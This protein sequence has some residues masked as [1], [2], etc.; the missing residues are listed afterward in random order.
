M[1]RGRQRGVRRR[2][3][4]HRPRQLRPRPVQLQPANSCPDRREL[5]QHAQ[6]PRSGQG[7]R[8]R[9]PEQTSAMPSPTPAWS[10]WTKPTRWEPMP[11]VSPARKETAG[12]PPSSATASTGYSIHYDKVPLETR[13]QLGAVLPQD[14][15]RTKPDGC[16]RCIPRL[17]PAAGRRRLGQR[18]DSEGPS[19]LRADRPQIR[20]GSCQSTLLK[21]TGK[22]DRWDCRC[23]GL[24]VESRG[25]SGSSR[26]C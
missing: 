19:P 13:G 25:R 6:V 20:A 8:A 11:S 17:R 10:T 9:F 1:H 21:L 24:P 4:R 3:A 2:R 14:L 23:R 12:W 26:L 15:D 5:S 7:A 22:S 16:D 18:T